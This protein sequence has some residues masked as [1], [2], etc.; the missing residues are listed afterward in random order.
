MRPS[1]GVLLLQA[2][3]AMR[4]I[5]RAG[6]LCSTRSPMTVATDFDAMTP[7]SHLIFHFRQETTVIGEMVLVLVATAQ[8]QVDGSGRRC[9]RFH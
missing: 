3:N 2:Q 5:C 6:N 1:F 9:P 8:A 4:A 7:Q